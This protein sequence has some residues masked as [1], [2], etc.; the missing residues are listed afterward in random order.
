MEAGKKEIAK[1]TYV[2]RKTFDFSRYLLN[3]VYHVIGRSLRS[4]EFRE[5]ADLLKGIKNLEEIFSFDMLKNFKNHEELLLLLKKYIREQEI[6]KKG[7]RNLFD[8]QVERTPIYRWDIENLYTKIGLHEENEGITIPFLIAIPSTHVSFEQQCQNIGSIDGVDHATAIYNFRNNDYVK[9]PPKP[10]LAK[11]VRIEKREISENER[12]INSHEA[13]KM[14][15]VEEG[16]SLLRF[17]PVTTL[18]YYGMVW[19]LGSE[20]Y[21]NFWG[22]SLKEI[23]DPCLRIGPFGPDFETYL[24]S[25]VGDSAIIAS[26]DE[27][28]AYK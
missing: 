22:E 12:R 28:L 18:C 1:I 21:E 23:M 27:R 7:G 24:K 10:Y 3:T 5:I 4:D 19:L 2:V 8:Y 20:A 6:I 11:G 14:L 17:F 25:N 13:E 26:C 9:I 15:T 16:M